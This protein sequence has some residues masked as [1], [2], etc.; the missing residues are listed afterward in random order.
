MLSL[1]LRVTSN[2]VAQQRPMCERDVATPYS[3][4]KVT[5]PCISCLLIKGCC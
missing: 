5:P 4:T 1:N 2:F 3:V